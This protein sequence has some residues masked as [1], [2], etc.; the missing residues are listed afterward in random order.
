MSNTMNLDHILYTV[1]WLQTIRAE[2]ALAGDEATVQLA[3][4][5]IEE[6]GEPL[7][8]IERLFPRA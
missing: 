2:A 1:P 8:Q 6:A 4:L 5:A 7:R 3:D